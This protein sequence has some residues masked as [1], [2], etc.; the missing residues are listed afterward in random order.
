MFKG[1]QPARRAGL[2]LRGGIRLGIRVSPRLVPRT[3]QNP[4]TRPH[5]A[6]VVLSVPLTLR[7]RH[8]SF[9][10]RSPAHKV[11]CT[12]FAP[13]AAPLRSKPALLSV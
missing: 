13:L 3:L 9:L 5:P 1:V 7:A 4:L 12:T 2:L 10:A 11:R 6:S 8:G